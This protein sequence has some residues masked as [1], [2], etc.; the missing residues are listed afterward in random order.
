MSCQSTFEVTIVF[1]SKMRVVFSRGYA[2][3]A[4]N[5]EEIDK[6]FTKVKETLEPAKKKAEPKS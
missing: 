5:E 3:G 2:P 6:I 1:C 4:L